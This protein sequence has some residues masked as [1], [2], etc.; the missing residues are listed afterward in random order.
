MP[1]RVLVDLNVGY[2]FHDGQWLDGTEIQLNVTNLFNKH[3]VSTIGSNG[4][5]NSRDSQTL[6][7]GAPREVFVSVRKQF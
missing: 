3:Y 1:S 6:L 2:R 7:A 4:F 5:T